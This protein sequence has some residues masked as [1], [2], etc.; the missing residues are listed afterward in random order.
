MKNKST[1]VLLML[2]V[3]LEF[4]LIMWE[5]NIVMKQQTL[6]RELYNDA[7]GRHNPIAKHNDKEL[8]RYS[9]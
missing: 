3:V 7:W 8:K 1:A 9:F 4:G 2:A 6:I 5:H